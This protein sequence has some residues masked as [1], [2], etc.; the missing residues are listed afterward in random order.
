MKRE[1]E[2]PDIGYMITTISHGIRQYF[3][4]V[5]SEYDV[6]FPQSRVLLRLF[7]QLEKADVNQRDL[8]FALGIK[9]SSVSSLVHN[10]EQKGLIRCERMHS[11]SR[12]K[13]II[14]TEKG[15]QLRDKLES[16]TDQAE[17]RLTE[18]L[19]HEEQ[20]QLTN[21]LLRIMENLDGQD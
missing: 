21:M 2:H 7:S 5:F 13:R 12:S 11:D 9:A 14:V 16:A 18:G 20:I 4:T 17:C 1:S 6:T 10:L 15:L 3:G 8:E 19:T